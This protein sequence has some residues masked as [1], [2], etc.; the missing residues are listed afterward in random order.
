[1]TIQTALQI[2]HAVE[3]D[4]TMLAALSNQLGYPASA[5]QV[6]LRLSKILPDPNQ[7][8]FVAEQPDLGVIG[9]I[10]LYQHWLVE[11]DQT[12]EIGGVVVDQNYRGRG[13]GKLLINAA[14]QWAQDAGCTGIHL[15]SNI[16]RKEAHQFY[17]NLGYQINKTQL[18]FIKLFDQL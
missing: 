15:R 10:H 11:E 1:M 4:A 16:L 3:K 5:P 14:E 18:S 13:I 2:R 9:W 7:A 8:I 17:L 12:A 6:A